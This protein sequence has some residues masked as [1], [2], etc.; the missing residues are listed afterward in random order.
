MSSPS[1]WTRVKWAARRPGFPFVTWV[2][3]S[4]CVMV[5]IAQ[6]LTGGFS[7]SGE[8]TAALWYVPLYT[9]TQ[10]WRMLSAVFIHGGVLHILFNMY[11]LYVMGQVLEPMLGRARFTALFLLGGL[12]GSVAVAVIGTINGAVLGASGAI[13]AMMG[14]FLAILRKQG[15]NNPQF[16]AVVVLNLAW[17]F[18][19]SGIAW[20]AHVGGLI[21][22]LALGAIYATYRQRWQRGALWA[23]VAALAV[24][25]IVIT[26]AAWYLRI[27]PWITTYYG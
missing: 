2:I 20:Q 6:F 24:G 19:F 10:P 14:A 26:V 12:G 23:S 7:S 27:S 15:I 22:G 1:V 3:I 5:F 13:F 25:L 18:F 17:G 21:V 9:A 4:V 11:S 8:V 16:L